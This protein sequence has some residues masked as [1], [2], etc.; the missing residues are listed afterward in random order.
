MSGQFF[1]FELM[2]T[3]IEKSLAFFAGLFE[4]DVLRAS[5]T[6]A[7]FVAPKGTEAP[8]FGVMPIQPEPGMR[9]HWIGYLMVDDVDR[10][11]ALAEEV[12]GRLHVTSEDDPDKDAASPRF[13]VI[14]DG[15]NAVLNVHATLEGRPPSDELP[16]IGHL[17][18]VELLTTD[19][20][21][22]AD[23]YHRLAGWEIGPEHP[24]GEEG[25]AHAL[26]HHERVFGLM[27]DL[28]AGSPV[29]PNW[30]FYLRVADL[31]KAIQHAR[32]LG[33]FMYEEP[34]DVDGGRRVLMMDPTGAPV[35]LWAAL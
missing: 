24:R 23:F 22:A 10:A 17:A 8:L 30:V 29:P 15:Q 16:P 14:T 5:E 28:P 27:R 6:A 25:V 19:R 32:A 31:D 9:S 3:D 20:E 7:Y 18:W 21:A 4:A 2:S 35:A 12:G 33:G 1:W 34:A 13:A 26:F 11:I